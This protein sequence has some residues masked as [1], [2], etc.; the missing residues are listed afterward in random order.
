MEDAFFTSPFFN[1]KLLF[2]RND[3]DKNAGLISWV[4]SL[5][6]KYRKKRTGRILRDQADRH[7]IVTFNYT[8]RNGIKKVHKVEPY[9]LRDGYFWGYDLDGGHIKRFHAS[10]LR[11][12]KPGNRSYIPKWS[13]KMNEK[14]AVKL[15]RNPKFVRIAEPLIGGLLGGSVA[16]GLS[17]NKSKSERLGP[18]V[19]SAL[20]GALAGALLSRRVRSGIPS[21]AIAKSQ[22]RLWSREPGKIDALV[23]YKGLKF[24]PAKDALRSATIREARIELGNLTKRN[25]PH[26]DQLRRRLRRSYEKQFLAQGLRQQKHDILSITPKQRKVLFGGI[27]GKPRKY[28]L[29]ADLEGYYT[30]GKNYR[31]NFLNNPIIKS[32]I[33]LAANEGVRVRKAWLSSLIDHDNEKYIKRLQDIANKKYFGTF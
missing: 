1:K 11:N 9:E 8:N 27:Y 19:G 30:R 5:I 18:T 31:A 28:K 3:F 4:N 22:A 15:L 2:A 16:Y 6:D 25:S 24:P 33:D 20:G 7:K 13:V 12:I 23:Y 21:R 10:K 17:S 32:Q 26:I 14:I 29:N